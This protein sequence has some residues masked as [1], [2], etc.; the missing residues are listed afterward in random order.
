M[1]ERSRREAHIVGVYDW[2]VGF[3]LIVLLCTGT[4]TGWRRYVERNFRFIYISVYNYPL[5]EVDIASVAGAVSINDSV[6]SV[7]SES[8]SSSISSSAPGIHTD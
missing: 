8:S 4:T 1:E 7:S 5:A 6:S 3:I 2:T